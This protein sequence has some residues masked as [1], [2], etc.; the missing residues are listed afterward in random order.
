MK[1]YGTYACG[2]EGAVQIYGPTKEHERKKS[3]IFSHLCPECEKLEF[4][5]KRDEANKKSMAAAAELGL[6][7]LTGSEKQI[8]W[9][10]TIR[11]EQMEFVNSLVKEREGFR[12]KIS[13]EILI[14]IEEWKKAFETIMETETSSKFWIENREEYQINKRIKEKCKELYF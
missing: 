11:N 4:Q 6:P 14:T 8:A 7:A 12:V 2:H 5:K 1:Y 13:N 9:A 10:T 3:Y